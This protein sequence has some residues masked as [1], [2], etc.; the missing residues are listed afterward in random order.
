MWQTNDDTVHTTSSRTKAPIHILCIQSLTWSLAEKRF[1]IEGT[2]PLLLFG[3]NDAHLRTVEQAFPEASI[4]ARGT[5]VYV[6]GDADAVESVEAVFEELMVLL[7]RND[8]LAEEDVETVLA[9]EQSNSAPAP[10]QATAAADADVVLHTPDGETIRPRTPNQ[11]KLAESARTNDVVFAIGPAGTGKTYMAVAMAVAALKEHRVKKIV[12]ARPAVE[13]GEQL[14]FL[15]GDFYEKIDPYLQPLYDALG[16]MMPHDK[17]AEYVETNRVEIVPLAYMRGRTMKSAFVIL[18]EAQNATTGQMKMFL[19][20]LGPNSRTIVTGDVTQTD[21]KNRRRSG[22]V[23][24][25]HILEGITGIDFVYL[26]PKDV[27]R[28]RL[29]RDIIA[30]YEK[31]EEG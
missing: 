23:Q 28:H 5:T 26:T 2:D 24:V 3:F 21:L 4:T 19:T 18:D 7:E 16:D 17:L 11:A 30:A 29:V 20:R 6:E 22:L 8:A 12:L 14:G 10:Q 9:L 13:A 31:H 15:P 1:S 25:Q 27:V